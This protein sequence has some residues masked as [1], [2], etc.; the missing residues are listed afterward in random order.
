MPRVILRCKINVFSGLLSLCSSMDMRD[1]F[2][3][4][5]IYTVVVVVVYLARL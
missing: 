5:L 1:H 2:L 4:C 3:I